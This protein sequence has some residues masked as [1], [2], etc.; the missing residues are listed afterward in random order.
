[1]GLLRSPHDVEGMFDRRRRHGVRQLDHMGILQ[2]FVGQR[3][4]FPRHRRREHQVLAL[5]GQQLENPLEVGKK[6]HVEHAIG[7]IEHQGLDAVERHMPLP[8]EIKQ[9]ARTDNQDIRPL[10]Q[11]ANLRRARDATVDRDRRYVGELRQG[12]DLGVNLHR[13]FPCGNDDQR[14]RTAFGVRQQALENRQGKRCRLAGSG[15]GQAPAHHVRQDPPES[16]PPEPA[17][18]RRIQA[19]RCLLWR[20]LRRSNCEN[21]ARGRE[22]TSIMWK[23]TIRWPP[24]F[25]LT[26]TAHRSN[27]Y[28]SDRS[29][30]E[31]RGAIYCQ[32]TLLCA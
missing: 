21:P 7:F 10:R 4:H 14:P 16:S 12:S 11:A 32:E 23:I 26:N 24:R 6:T 25:A 9:P 28:N 5:L 29:E 19:R 15:L 30:I 17:A 1:M 27:P 20:L 18:A 2:H 13:Q 8:I 3:A 22:D 31:P